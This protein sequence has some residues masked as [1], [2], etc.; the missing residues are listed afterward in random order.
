MKTTLI[1]LIAVLT[2][3][4]GFSQQLDLQA[5]IRSGVSNGLTCRVLT[6]PGTYTEGMLLSRNRGAQLYVLRGQTIPLSKVPVEGFSYSSAWGGHVGFSGFNPRREEYSYRR[7]IFM[8]VLGIDYYLALNFTMLKFPLT[9][10]VDYKPFVEIVPDRIF[11]MNL[12]D[13]GFTVRYQ[14]TTKI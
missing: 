7:N 12:W 1:F 4:F 6:G 10:S 9:L 2:A 5:G 3:G 13:F 8:P 11:R 14:F